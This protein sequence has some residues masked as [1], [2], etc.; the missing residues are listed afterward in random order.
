MW[1]MSCLLLNSKVFPFSG[2]G[3]HEETTFKGW[4]Y[5]ILILLLEGSY[6]EQTITIAAKKSLCGE[7]A[8]VVQRLGLDLTIGQILDKLYHILQG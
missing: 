8:K 3:D 2:E 1:S 4:K 5:E 6:S 7:A